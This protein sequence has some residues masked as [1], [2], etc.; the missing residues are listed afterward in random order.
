MAQTANTIFGSPAPAVAVAH[1]GSNPIARSRI[2]RRRILGGALGGAAASLALPALLR[3]AVAA[4]VPDVTR[5]WGMF[6][7]RFVKGARIV[8]TGNGGVSHS[9]GQGIGLLAAVQSGDRQSFDE[10]YAWTRATLRRPYDSLH[11]WRYKPDMPN[12]VDDLNNATDGDLLITLAL[13][14]AAE[15]WDVTAYYNTAMAL[16]RDIHSA[17][18]R[19]TRHGL[20]LLPGVSG[21]T[22]RSRVTVNPS[23]YVFPAIQRMKL[24]MPSP[25]WDRVIADG[26]ALMRDGRFGQHQ[27]PP[28]WLSVHAVEPLMPAERWPARFSFDAVRVPLYMCWGGL[29]QDPIVGSVQSFWSG[30]GRKVAPAWT[31]LNTG[32]AAPYAQ[33]EGMIA[34]RKYTEAARRGDGRELDLPSI[35]TAS[36]YY[37]A[38]LVLLVTIAHSSG[39]AAV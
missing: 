5:A 17:L 14:L 29:S 30:F 34:I 18:L 6:K 1:P 15:R 23:Y 22:E 12:H 25:E 8:D 28:D 19:E 32:E 21:F 31:D 4:P 26:L 11:A 10:M 33:A 13:F 37:Q 38:A 9:E 2:T 39:S 27:L 3:P 7:E 36:D 24:E 16:T 20:V 35:A